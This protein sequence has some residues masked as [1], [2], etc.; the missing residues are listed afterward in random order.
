MNQVK[1]FIPLLFI[2][3]FS[4][5]AFS[6]NKLDQY[7]YVS[8]PKQLSLQKSPN[9]YQINSILR[10]YLNKYDFVSFIQG[11]NYPDDVKPCEI[12]SLNAD[13]SGFLSTKTVLTFTDC[14]GNNVYTSIEGV[15]RTKEFKLAYYEALRETLKDPN[16]QNHKYTGQNL[17]AQKTV[18]KNE[19]TSAKASF[20]LE[21]KN[22]K[23]TFVETAVKDEYNVLVNQESIGT[24]KKE[25]NND[26]YILE[27]G[28]MSGT[29]NFDD[30][31]NFTL[32]R[33]NPVNNIKITDIMARVN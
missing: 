2:S 28:P 10:D 21:F 32:T 26:Q 1:T 7:K 16:I 18:D 11:E 25:S 29:G 23:Y 5:T 27:A 19:P 14:Y 9:Q 31:G 4:L 20:I 15:S 17:T 8:I 33:V 6:Q 12:L 13:K 30:F 3:L 24:L 22:T